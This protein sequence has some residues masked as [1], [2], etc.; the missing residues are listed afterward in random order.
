MEPI[1]KLWIKLTIPASNLAEQGITMSIQRMI[2]KLALAFA[3]KKGMDAFKG[4]GGIDGVKTA[5]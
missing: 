1:P 5:L 4:M 3:A 2:T